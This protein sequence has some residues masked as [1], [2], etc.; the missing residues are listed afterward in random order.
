MCIRYCKHDD[1]VSKQ[2]QRWAKQTAT[3][4]RFGVNVWAG[5][6]N[7]QPGEQANT[8]GLFPVFFEGRRTVSEMEDGRGVGSADLLR[9]RQDEDG[10]PKADHKML[11]S[12]RHD[13]DA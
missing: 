9:S 1:T 4:A 3:G 11:P 2:E 12:V 10:R 5:R 13:P 7:L 8:S 6:S